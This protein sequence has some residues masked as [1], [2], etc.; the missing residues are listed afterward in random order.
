MSSRLAQCFTITLPSAIRNQ[1]VWVVAKVR[2]VGGKTAPTSPSRSNS[3]IGPWW[4]PLIVLWMTNELAIG[5]G[6]VDLERQVGE[7]DP[8]PQGGGVEP[9]RAGLSGRG[10]LVLRLGVDDPFEVGQVARHHEEHAVHAQLLGLLEAQPGRWMGGRDRWHRSPPAFVSAG[11]RV[12]LIY[13]FASKAELLRRAIEVALA[14]DDEPVAVHDRPTAR[15]VYE[16]ETA[17][18]VLRRYAVMSGELASRAGSIYGVLAGAADAEPELANLLRT[19]EAQRLRA[20]TQVAEAVHARGGLP[21]GR[22]VAE[23][24]DTIWLCNAPE[25][26][27]MLTAKRR[28][29]TRRYVAWVRNAL[30]NLVT[31]P[32]HS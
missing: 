32:P 1:W 31:A 14:G 25:V 28:W 15:W 27:V 7:G 26:Y 3:T 19:F 11:S 22:T 23:A 30:L 9:A 18:E 8:Q 16:A 12:R 10:R 20:A 13:G 21:P 6:V 17:E 24:R 5:H 4:R 29:S 2:P